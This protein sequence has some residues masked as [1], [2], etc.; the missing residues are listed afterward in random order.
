MNK[1]LVKEKKKLD[2]SKKK[3]P[4]FLT[5]ITLGFATLSHGPKA[6]TKWEKKVELTESLLDNNQKSIAKNQKT[7]KKSSERIPILEE[8]ARRDIL[9]IKESYTEV[10]SAAN[11]YKNNSRK[12]LEL[13][14]EGN[15]NG[16]AGRDTENKNKNFAAKLPSQPKNRTT[17]TVFSNVADGESYSVREI[18]RLLS[19]T[20]GKIPGVFLIT[21]I[22]IK[23]DGDSKPLHYVDSTKNLLDQITNFFDYVGRPISEPFDSVQKSHV[24]QIAVYT[25]GHLSD[26]DE[27]AQEMYLKMKEIMKENGVGMK[28]L[29]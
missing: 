23:H 10:K 8:K 11:F 27:Q 20:K 29:G 17:T 6:T 13:L 7:I 1:K 2:S 18:L 26:K 4:I 12:I 19:K 24:F 22:P 28:T 21:A 16:E 14:K 15:S 3:C 9:V 5:V 25:Y